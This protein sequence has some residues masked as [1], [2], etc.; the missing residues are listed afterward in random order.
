[1]NGAGEGLFA[2]CALSGGAD[3]TDGDTAAG[4]A[5]GRV[6]RTTLT[7]PAD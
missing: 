4:H 2:R 1:M 3:E 7:A 6:A 5:L